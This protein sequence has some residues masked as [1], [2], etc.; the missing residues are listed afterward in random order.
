M[1]VRII[2]CLLCFAFMCAGQK[3]PAA[4]I[5]VSA[6]Q[7]PVGGHHFDPDNPF[8]C[9]LLLTQEMDRGSYKVGVLIDLA[10]MFASSSQKDRAVKVITEALQT[11]NVEEKETI[12]E[13]FLETNKSGLLTRI[14][15][16]YA[17]LGLRDQALQLIKMINGPSQKVIGLTSVAREFIKT[18]QKQKG[19]ELLHQ[20]LNAMSP[21]HEE[22][23]SLSSIAKGFAQAG[24]FQ[25]ALKVA[26]TIPK[27]MIPIEAQT[28][29]SIASEQAKAGQKDQALNVLRQALQLVRAIQGRARD[30]KA[31]T[32]SDISRAYVDAGRKDRALL[33]LSQALQA[34]R[35]V[36][37]NN[38]ELD[39]VAVA[40]AKAGQYKKALQ[41]A[42]SIDYKGSQVDALIGM[43]REYVEAGEK[44]IASETLSQA[45]QANKAEEDEDGDEDQLSASVE[46][47]VEYARAG[48]KDKASEVL[49]QTLQLSKTLDDDDKLGAM[50]KI[51]KAYATV[52]EN[53]DAKA[54]KLLGEICENF[55]KPPTLTPDE[56][57]KLN[58]VEE[59]ADRFI[60]RWHEALDFNVLF[61]E[62]FVSNPEQR[63]RNLG[64]FYGV[65]KQLSATGYDPGFGK[66]INEA[67]VR[68]GFMAFWNLFYLGQEYKLAFQKPEDQEQ[69]IAPEIVEAFNDLRKIKLDK[70]YMIL[71]QIKE[72][73]AKANHISSLI[74]KYLTRES[75]ETPLYK[76]NLRQ[77]RQGPPVSLSMQRMLDRKN[78]KPFRILRGFPEYG[79]GKDIEVYS[80]NHCLFAFFFVEEAG[81]LKVLTLGFE[82]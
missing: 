54:K 57:Q 24:Q 4:A 17:V 39:K 74:R 36:K 75:F 14:A 11:M 38:V 42:K 59:A 37:I 55:G 61:D 67:V 70:K 1:C 27:K 3:Y 60:K 64:L 29:A 79:V 80:L 12:A 13:I 5:Q 82:L 45:I 18:G 28:F 53:I 72:Y 44:D 32:L 15:G 30:V 33:T 65:Y 77:C 48:R 63:R 76:A 6:E 49:F 22:V 56:Q 34:A 71:T 47:A 51:A 40:Y 43:A 58:R 20:A 68:E 8:D 69:H 66:D 52:G 46:I 10:E 23:L 35:A 41:I 81:Q 78:E 25:E 26:T 7:N 16:V 2:A 50:V 9:A 21:S 73:I 62:T 31:A 19:I